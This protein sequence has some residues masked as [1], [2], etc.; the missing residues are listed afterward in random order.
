MGSTIYIWNADDDVY[1]TYNAST[2]VGTNDGSRYIA[3]GQ[4]FFVANSGSAPALTSTE[5]VKAIDQ[6]PD[7]LNV[8]GVNTLRLT[9]GDKDGRHVEAVVGLHPEAQAGQDLL[10]AIRP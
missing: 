3:S 6:D 9:L 4:A 1:A 5:M 8:A 2:D 10:D 7:F